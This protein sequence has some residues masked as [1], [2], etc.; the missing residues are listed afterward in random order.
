MK[1]AILGSTGY[2]GTEL[3]R[4]LSYHPGIQ[5]S[6]LTADRTAGQ[7]YKSVYPQYSYRSDL[8]ALTNWESSQ[9][10][11]ESCDVAF[12]CLPH[13]TTQNIISIL[14]KTPTLKVRVF[15]HENEV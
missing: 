14:A 12:C 6:V 3:V 11:I 15:M 5:F 9:K 2:T 10:D 8:P 13:G 4:L 7:S 1:V